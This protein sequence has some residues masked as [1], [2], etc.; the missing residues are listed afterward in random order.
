MSPIA[1]A[2]INEFVSK[3]SSASILSPIVKRHAGKI[4]QDPAVGAAT[5]FPMDAFTSKHEKALATLY[6]VSLHI[7]VKLLLDIYSINF[8]AVPDVSPLTEGIASVKVLKELSL[9][10]LIILLNLSRILSSVSP[11][12]FISF[13]KAISC[14]FLFFS[15]QSFINCAAFSYILLQILPVLKLALFIFY[16]L[17]S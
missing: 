6:R 3:V 7:I 1:L 10:I 17:Q 9:I 14:I 8:F 15:L 5:I 12:S 4:P 16:V 2:V 13:S 11:V